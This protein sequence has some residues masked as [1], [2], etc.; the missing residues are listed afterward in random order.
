MRE[1][2]AETASSPSKMLGGLDV[3]SWFNQDALSDVTIK[4]SGKEIKCHKLILSARSEYFTKMLDP[5]GGFVEASASVI[6]LKED[7][8]AALEALLRYIYT[9]KY[10]D[11]EEKRAN[12]WIFHLNYS[13]VARKY[14]FEKESLAAFVVFETIVKAI[15]IP[16][17]LYD[18]IT[19]LPQFED[20]VPEVSLV[21]TA[22][23]L[24]EANLQ[25]LLE[26]EEFR[27]HIH[28]N[29]EILWRL[30]VKV[31]PRR[32]AAPEVV[33][34][35]VYRCQTRRCGYVVR[36]KAGAAPMCPHHDT[37]PTVAFVSWVSPAEADTVLSFAAATGRPGQQS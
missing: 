2:S 23:K 37:P 15:T 28:A 25:P 32:F 22:D 21:K 16:E 1:K 19:T 30:M 11:D 33:P 20:L 35:N 24:I 14:G 26:L 12:D 7:D 9:F 4:F 3:A 5:K 31:V 18:V 27:L 17:A 10:I 36:A 8:P 13:I 34:V 6:E 29:E